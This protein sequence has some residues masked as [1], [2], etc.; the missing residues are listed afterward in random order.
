MNKPA[1][2]LI[3]DDEP[4]TIEIL[5]RQL[6]MENYKVLKASSGKKSLELLKKHKLDLVLMDIKM[7][8]MDGFE[9][10]TIIR[11]TVKDF[12]PIIIVTATR[13]DTESIT[14]GFGV[15]ADDYIVIPCSKEELL[16]RIKA[17]LRI[18]E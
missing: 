12:I 8:G 2:I 11:D 13:D 7:P 15:G 3:V 1:H 16:A 6:S 4:D 5:S 9:T 17:M 14:R 10:I 18:K